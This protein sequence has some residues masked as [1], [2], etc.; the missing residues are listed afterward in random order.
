[1]RAAAVAFS[2]HSEDAA[3]SGRPKA[4]R[5]GMSLVF[6]GRRWRLAF[7]RVRGMMFMRFLKVREPVATGVAT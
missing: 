4:G 2:P 1:M 5:S 7:Q 6:Y 3:R